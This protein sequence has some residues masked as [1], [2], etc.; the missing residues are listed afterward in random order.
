MSTF[1]MLLCAAGV[2]GVVDHSWKAH[3]WPAIKAKIWPGSVPISP[4]GPK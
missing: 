4:P 1:W 3:I 2:G